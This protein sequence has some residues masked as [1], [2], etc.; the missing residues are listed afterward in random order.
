MLIAARVKSLQAGRDAMK[1]GMNTM[2]LLAALLVIGTTA[3]ATAQTY[4]S[5][6]VRM[7]VPFVAG[8]SVDAIARVVASALSDNMGQPVIVENRAGAGGNLGADMV[9]KAAPDG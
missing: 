9:A 8:G 2:R 3:S 6:P 1:Y 4:P 7:V 5:R